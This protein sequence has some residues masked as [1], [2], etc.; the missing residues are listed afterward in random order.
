MRRLR[1]SLAQIN[2]TVGDLDGNAARII[3]QIREAESIGADIVAFPELALTGYP[4]ED[5]VLRRGFVEDNLA[6]LD[7]VRDATR[8]L[9]VTTIVGFVD[10]AHD[11]F[12][13]AAVIHDGQMA[14]AYHKQYLPNYGV[15]DEARYFRPGTGVQ[16]FDIAG[17]RVGVTICEDI[18]YSSGPM[19]DQCL[20]GAEVVVNINGS[21]FH[22]G[23]SQQREQM[24]ATRASDNAVLTLYCN[25]VG[26]QD[27]LIFDGGST[28][29]GP[30]GDLIARA[31]MFREHLL[32]VDL[33]VEEV[34]QTRLH[35]PRLRRLPQTEAEL[36]LV[37]GDR[38]AERGPALDAELI[39]A[40][41]D[42][43]Q[44]YEALV[45]GTRDYVH[46]TGFSDVVIALSGGI[47]STLTAVVAV[48]ALGPDH[49]RGV[50]MPSRYSS[51]GSV[52][53]ARAL[54]DNLGIQMD[55]LPIEGP[56]QA[57]IDTLAPLFE[58]LPQ[59][60]TEENLQARIRGVLMMAISNKT[61]ALVLTT[62]NKSESATGYTTLYGDMTG[63]LAVIQDVPK[64]LVYR[65]SELVNER[66]G[67]E[68]IPVSV[69]TKPPSAELRPDQ[70][71][72]QS[73][74]PYERLD[75]I[76]EAFVEEDRSLDEIVEAGF[77]E[78]DVKRVMSL[79]TGAEYKRRQAAPG[80][81]ITPRAFGRDRRF[82]IAN[83]Y[84]G[85]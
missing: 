73:L 5:L 14:G 37:S 55:V 60:V 6:M 78:A 61:G 2:S 58:G 42:D 76:L 59:D 83:R 64:L 81:R 45:L 26:G 20:A 1:A 74:M 19:Q 41:A 79:V 25:L 28:V 47:D 10:Y 38:P 3:E 52:A 54:A 48:D 71:D 69:L 57:N 51:E 66:A 80:L 34:R 21:P 72:E 24:L 31:P 44:V 32:T 12:N 29:F 40:L 11:I 53:D 36:Q 39:D 82:P 27:H 63:G 49:V 8:G 33:D 23:K 18:W 15:F 16:L 9:H 62:S 35:D 65:L 4:P 70:F 50:S 46:K 43:E 13:A 30:G 68:V 7:R 75:P 67:R 17:A 84:R 85:F 22:A 77:D 56:Y